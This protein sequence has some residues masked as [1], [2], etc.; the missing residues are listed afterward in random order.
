MLL[1]YNWYVSRQG[2]RFE[3][4]RS[5]QMSAWSTLKH[6][7]CSLRRCEL[8][9][10]SSQLTLPPSSIFHFSLMFFFFSPAQNRPALFG[11][12]SSRLCRG[13][14]LMRLRYIWVNFLSGDSFLTNLFLELEMHTPVYRQTKATWPPPT[15][16]PLPSSSVKVK[17]GGESCAKRTKRICCLSMQIRKKGERHHGYYPSGTEWSAEEGEAGDLD[18]QIIKSRPVR[19]LMMRF[20][21][22]R[23]SL[24]FS[25][26]A[27]EKQP[28]MRI[29][30]APFLPALSS[31]LLIWD[32]MESRCKRLK[33]RDGRVRHWLRSRRFDWIPEI[34]GEKRHTEN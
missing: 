14:H 16:A 34:T 18:V 23:S 30:L 29:T 2:H 6:L 22:R 28:W 10:V 27:V 32:H 4:M 12:F 33:A 21:R 3:L 13:I 11:S 5:H 1:C 17:P 9:S 31:S 15:P 20:S 24:S 26:S 25:S 8:F 7:K 19:G